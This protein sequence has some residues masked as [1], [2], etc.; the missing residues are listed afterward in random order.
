VSIDVPTGWKI[1][2]APGM[3]MDFARRASANVTLTQSESFRV[4]I[5]PDSGAQN[6]WDRLVSGS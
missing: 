5:V 2:K 4:H 6:L 1:D 3:Q